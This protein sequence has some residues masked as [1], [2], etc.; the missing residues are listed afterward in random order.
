VHLRAPMIIH[1]VAAGGGSFD[2]T[3]SFPVGPKAL[4]QPSQPT[5]G[6]VVAWRDGLTCWWA[7]SN[8]Y[9]LC[10]ANADN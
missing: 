2:L 5:T 7:R 6:A 9:F 3:A 10:L 8:R 4:R 1:T